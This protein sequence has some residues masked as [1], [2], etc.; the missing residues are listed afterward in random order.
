MVVLSQPAIEHVSLIKNCKPTTFSSEIPIIDLSK[1]DPKARLVAACKEFGFFKVINHG[2][3]MEFITEL[4]SEAIKFFSL[5]S[6]EKEKIGPPDPLGYGNKRI[7][8]NGDVG[9]VEFLLLTINREFNSQRFSSTFG[10][11]P[12][13]FL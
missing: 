2:V 11:N 3:P 10:K 13:V 4:E 8:P 1:P 5:P 12:E 6:F 7:G 9:W